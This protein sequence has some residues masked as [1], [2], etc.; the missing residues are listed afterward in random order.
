M[1]SRFFVIRRALHHACRLYVGESLRDSHS[2]LGETGLRSRALS[3]RDSLA[4]LGET[5]L[6]IHPLSVPSIHLKASCIK[7]R[8]HTIHCDSSRLPAS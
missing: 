6:R 1:F 8:A 4:G 7:S 2:R 5:G 3:R